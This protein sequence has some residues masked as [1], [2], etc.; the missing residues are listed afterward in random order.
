MVTPKNA[1]RAD[2]CIFAPIGPSGLRVFYGEF[3]YPEF[4]VEYEGGRRK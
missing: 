1:I 2:V 3:D 4:S